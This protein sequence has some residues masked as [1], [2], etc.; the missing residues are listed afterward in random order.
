[1]LNGRRLHEGVPLRRTLGRPRRPSGIGSRIWTERP[2]PELSSR[3]ILALQDAVER[4]FV[5][6]WSG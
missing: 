5:R 4:R 2:P 6:S 1:M 3:G